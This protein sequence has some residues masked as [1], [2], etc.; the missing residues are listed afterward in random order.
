V[1]ALL[2]RIVDAREHPE[3]V[4]QVV[5]TYFTTVVLNSKDE[6]AVCYALRVLDH[7]AEP[8]PDLPALVQAV[9]RVVF[10]AK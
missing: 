10:A 2:R 9:G 3:S 8:F 7:F 6:R 5:C 4:R 1:Q